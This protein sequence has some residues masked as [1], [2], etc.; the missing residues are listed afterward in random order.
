[1]PAHST[2]NTFLCGDKNRQP[3]TCW[4]VLVNRLLIRVK[5]VPAATVVKIVT[6]YDICSYGRI[7]RWNRNNAT[8]CE[9]L[10]ATRSIVGAVIISSSHF[11]ICG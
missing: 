9:G 11:D 2:R 10:C 3:Q 4:Y 7:A 5:F 6:S 1:M 8:K